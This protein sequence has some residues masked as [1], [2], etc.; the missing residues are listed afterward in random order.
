VCVCHNTNAVADAANMGSTRPLNEARSP[1]MKRHSPSQQ[2]RRPLKQTTPSPSWKDA[3]KQECLERARQ[4][5]QEAIWKSR[6]RQTARQLVE[7]ELRESGVAI[8]RGDHLPMPS[9]L[10]TTSMS[11]D[12]AISEAELYELMQEVEEELQRHDGELCNNGYECFSLELTQH[13]THLFHEPL[14][15]YRRTS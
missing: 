10:D 4:K 14:L 2:L 7:D 6:L 3:L 1:W 11:D 9:S 13:E 8:V 15:Y 5:R 12:Y